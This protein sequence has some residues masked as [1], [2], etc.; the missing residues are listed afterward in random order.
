A[1]AGAPALGHRPERRAGQRVIDRE[2]P[3]DRLRLV[4][5]TVEQHGQRAVQSLDDLA[6]VEERGGYRHGAIRPL[7]GQQLVVAEQLPDPA[8]WDAEA[9]SGLGQG[10]PVADQSV[11]QGVNL[12][13]VPE[14][15]TPGPWSN[16][17]T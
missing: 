10:E 2:Q 12:C 1:P 8:R 6:S 15:P 16:P 14:F 9:V 17:D 4:E 11:G 3:A 7:N 13:H 5:A